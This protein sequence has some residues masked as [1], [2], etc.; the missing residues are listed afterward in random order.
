[1]SIELMAMSRYWWSCLLQPWW[2]DGRGAVGRDVGGRDG[3]DG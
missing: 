3:G 2:D 1:M